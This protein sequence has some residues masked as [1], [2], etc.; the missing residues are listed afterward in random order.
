MKTNDSEVEEEGIFS[1]G[2]STKMEEMVGK[3]LKAERER[4][5]IG[6]FET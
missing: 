5:K 2:K 3:Q 4:D 6:M 1:F